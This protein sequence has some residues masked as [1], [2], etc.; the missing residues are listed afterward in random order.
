R[1]PPPLRS[2]ARRACGLRRR[3]EREV[4]AA[5]HPPGPARCGEPRG[6]AGRRRAVG[7]FVPE[8]AAAPADAGAARTRPVRRRPREGRG[9]AAAPGQKGNGGRSGGVGPAMRTSSGKPAAGPRDLRISDAAAAAL[10]HAPLASAAVLAWFTAV[11]SGY[12]APMAENLLLALPAAGAAAFASGAGLKRRGAPAPY[13]L[14]ALV[15]CA[16]MFCTAFGLQAG[17]RF[18]GGEWLL[19]LAFPVLPVFAALAAGACPPRGRLRSSPAWTS[20]AAWAAAAV[21]L[22]VVDGGMRYTEARQ[23]RRAAAAALGEYGT[24]AVLDAPGWRLAHAYD[25]SVFPELVYRDLL[26]RTV[27]LGST[28]EPLPEEGA[29]EGEPTADVLAPGK[30]GTEP[31]EPR[32]EG[33][34]VRSGMLVVEMAGAPVDRYLG[35]DTDRWPSGWTEVR[36]ESAGGRYVR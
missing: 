5:P 22:L 33:C 12:P 24:V 30:C 21:M 27:L 18:V 4:S 16:A 11:H 34:E 3:E 17:V 31:G 2:G 20:G 25:G 14:G 15:G 19:Y 6:R 8:R 35:D 1:F 29:G 9:V 36:T 13:R 23:E 7:P 32:E 26:G 28:P 10:V